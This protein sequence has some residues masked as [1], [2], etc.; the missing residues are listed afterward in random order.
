MDV[1]GNA[2]LVIILILV[3]V[4][5]SYACRLLVIISYS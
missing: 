3:I 1:T 5:I 2:V 4:I